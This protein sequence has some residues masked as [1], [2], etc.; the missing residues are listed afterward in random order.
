MAWGA[1]PSYSAAGIVNASNYSAGP[2]APGS[3]VTIFGSG[4]AR[5]ATS[6]PASDNASSLPY[7]LNFARVYVQDQLVPLLFVSPSQINFV[8]PYEQLAGPTK[9]RV[10]SDGVSGPEAVV[11]LADAAPALFPGPNGY[12]LAT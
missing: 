12:A 10:V 9:V 3:V 6:F 5:S 11:Q 7:E 4:L 2:F 8:M 1:G